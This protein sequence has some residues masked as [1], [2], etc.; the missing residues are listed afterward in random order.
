MRTIWAGILILLLSTHVFAL[1]PDP[2]HPEKPANCQLHTLY[3][4]IMELQPESDPKWAMNLSNALI[5]HAKQYNMD[6]WLSL[7]IAMQES[8][9]RNIHR[10]N[11]TIVFKEHCEQGKPCEKTYDIVEGHS[12]ITVFQ[13]HVNTIINYG[14]DPLRL[15]Q[16]LDYLVDW[17]YRILKRK[18]QECRSYEREAW[19]CYHSRTP[20][21]HQRYVKQ[22]AQ[23]YHGEKTITNDEKSAPKKIVVVE[24]KSS[25]LNKLKQS[26]MAWFTPKANP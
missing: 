18:Q 26:F 1:I 15:T 2:T 17:H 14:I 22:V 23:Y 9:L 11:K 25:A 10:N 21:L 6:P 5:K 12:D 4:K 20:V 24:N 8:G 13:L 3:C 19:A 16:D 7:A